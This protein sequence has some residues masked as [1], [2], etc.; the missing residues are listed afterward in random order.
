MRFAL[1]NDERREAS[2]GLMGYCPGCSQQMVLKCGSQRVWHWAHH[3]ARNCDTWWEP[4]TPWHRRWKNQFPLKWQ[5][6]IRHDEKGEKHIA[7][8]IT[9]NGLVV[10][11]QHSH[12][13]AP[14]KA[15]REAFYGNL[16]WIV[17]GT[18]LKRDRHRF[19]KRENLFRLPYTN[20]V[21]ITR[22][23]ELSLPSVWVKCTKPV[24]FDFEGFAVANEIPGAM[25]EKL[26]CLLPGRIDGYATVVGISRAW[27]VD[28]AQT[29]QA[30]IPVQAITR[31]VTSELR[32][33][34]VSAELSARRWDYTMRPRSGLFRNPRR[35]RY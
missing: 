6:I 9:E 22:S 2:P 17:N 19:L 35:R 3:G 27:F 10:E 1:V 20:H 4:E 12:L 16:L 5:E 32:R 15:A 13:P 7:D 23:P 11:F 30:V 34:R 28:V 21:F 25:Q 14:E 33:Q 26:W 29:R 8:V 18:R 31:M 24:V